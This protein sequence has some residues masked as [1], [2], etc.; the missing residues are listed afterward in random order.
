MIIAFKGYAGAGKDAMAN[1][2]VEEK[3]FLR[4]SFAGV[5]R[6][7]MEAL[8]PIVFAT[9]D[10]V[11]PDEPIVKRY[12]DVISEYGYVEAKAQFAEVRDLLQRMGTEVGRNILGQN[13]WV[14]AAMKNVDPNLDYVVTDMRF[15]NEYEAVKQ[16]G[17]ICVNVLR[18][19]VGPV[20][21]HPSETAIDEFEYD[22]TIQ[23]DG[24]LEDLEGYALNLYV[25]VGADTYFDDFMVQTGRVDLES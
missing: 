2:L 14:E 16:A 18:P 24:T 22:Y 5:L 19:G 17:G 12:K 9:G 8:D 10:G 15:P 4:L 11:D 6:D 20:N 13:I 25:E 3:G 23:N 7:C 21:A 1:V